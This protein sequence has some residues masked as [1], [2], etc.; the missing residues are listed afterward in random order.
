MYKYLKH[1][2]FKHNKFISFSCIVGDSIDKNISRVIGLK[3]TL[4]LSRK[5]IN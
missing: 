1:N 5:D 4:N 3:D 2:F